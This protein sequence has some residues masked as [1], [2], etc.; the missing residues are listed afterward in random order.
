MK[1]YRCS[2]GM[3][4]QRKPYVAIDV[5]EPKTY[6]GVFLGFLKHILNI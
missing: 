4:N 6:D 5:M 3:Y 2:I 1:F